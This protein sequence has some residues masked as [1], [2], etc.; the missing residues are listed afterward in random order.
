M[1]L[2]DLLGKENWDFKRLLE[3]GRLYKKGMTEI[4]YSVLGAYLSN[5]GPRFATEIR[6]EIRRDLPGTQV[7]RQFFE[8]IEGP[9]SLAEGGT[10]KQGERDLRRYLDQVLVIDQLDAHKIK[11][12]SIFDLMAPDIP[13]QYDLLIFRYRFSDFE[14]PY[15]ETLDLRDEAEDHSRISERALLLYVGQESINR[16]KNTYH[17]ELRKALVIEIPSYDRR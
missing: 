4:F 3:E 2:V 9:P 14:P 10:D 5:Y 15:S 7:R 13:S 16:F 12:A 8:P 6:A 17:N 1:G 11:A